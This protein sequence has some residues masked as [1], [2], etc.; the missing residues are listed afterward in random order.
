M[1]PLMGGLQAFHDHALITL[2]RMSSVCSTRYEVGIA[3]AWHRISDVDIRDGV[4]SVTFLSF[5]LGPQAELRLKVS[6]CWHTSVSF[7]IRAHITFGSL[8]H[9]YIPRLDWL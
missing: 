3:K 4:D 8:E 9:K 5:S 6:N 2:I 7:E 1:H